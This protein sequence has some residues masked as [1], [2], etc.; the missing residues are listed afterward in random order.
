MECTV[1][2]RTV[3]QGECSVERLVQI[4]AVDNT[5][6]ATFSNARQLHILDNWVYHLQ[7]LK[8]LRAGLLVGLMNMQASE[9]KYVATAAGLRASGVGVYA[10]RSCDRC[11]WRCAVEV[12]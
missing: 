8:D 9:P 4:H 5:V 1:V 3:L 7:Q 11:L 10:V 6:V 12:R 2:G